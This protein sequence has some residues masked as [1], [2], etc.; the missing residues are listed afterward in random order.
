M[1]YHEALAANDLATIGRETSGK[2][3]IKIFDD[4]GAEASAG[5]PGELCVRGNMVMK[6]YLSS[7]DNANSYF[8][9][10]FRT[11]DVAYRAPNGNFYLVS[12][13][14]ELINVGG[15]K[16]SPATIEAAI[17]KAV[18]PRKAALIEKNLQA[19]KLGM[20]A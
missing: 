6:G 7:E 15:E 5:T 13:K 14:K 12:R 8:G 4:N 17:R 10:Y 11:G 2:I 9:E 3:Q 19:L 20:Q 18:P 16:V 1:E